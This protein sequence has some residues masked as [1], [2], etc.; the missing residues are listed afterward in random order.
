M[1]K[2]KEKRLQH[3]RQWGRDNRKA[4]YAEEIIKINENGGKL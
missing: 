3:N 2:D 4:K 1:Y